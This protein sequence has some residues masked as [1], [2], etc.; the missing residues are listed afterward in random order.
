MIISGPAGEAY[1]SKM[2]AYAAVIE[3]GSA[4]GL[5][6]GCVPGAPGAHSQGETIEEMMANLREVLDM[7]V[8]DG[9]PAATPEQQRR[10]PSPRE[11]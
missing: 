8:D 3:R 9:E 10:R 2:Q 5:Y 7:L 4:N 11:N 6:V 1:T